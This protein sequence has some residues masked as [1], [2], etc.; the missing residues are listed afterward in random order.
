M[1]QFFKETKYYIEQVS[2]VH[3]RKKSQAGFKVQ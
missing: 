3:R 2:Q 1:K